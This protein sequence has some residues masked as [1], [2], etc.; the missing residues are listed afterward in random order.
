MTISETTSLD[1]KYS[2]M[3]YSHRYHDANHACYIWQINSSLKTQLNKKIFSRH[4]LLSDKEL[5]IIRDSL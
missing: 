1:Q 5:W 2:F 4:T 3:T